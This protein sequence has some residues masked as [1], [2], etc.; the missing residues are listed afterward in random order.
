[1][2]S[3]EA[4][5]PEMPSFR[6]RRNT[7]WVDMLKTEEGRRIWNAFLLNGEGIKMRGLVYIYT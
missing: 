5:R 7:V 6:V 1:M 4:W 2:G 3:V